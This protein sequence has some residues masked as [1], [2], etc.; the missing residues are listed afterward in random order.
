MKNISVVGLGKLGLCVAAC[1]AEKDYK[2]I[3]V[4]IDTHKIEQIN[5]GHNPIPETGLT[6]LVA[7]GKHNLTATDD[8]RQAVMNSEATFIV[9]ATPSDADGSFSNK[10]LE[11]SLREIGKVLKD[12]D[13]YHLIVITS[14][15]MPGTTEHVAK[16]I[17]ESTTGKKCG[18]D[19]G[20]AYNP[21]FIALGSVIHDFLNPDFI[22]IGEVATKDGEILEDIYKKTCDNNPKFARMS[23]VNA[24]IA[25]ISLN[26]YVTMK[27]SYANSLASI[28]E[29]VPGANSDDITNAIGLD[30][31]I[32][33]KYLKGGLGFGGPCFPRDNIA[34]AAFARKLG[35][36]AKLAEMV[37]EVNR[38]QALKIVKIVK[39]NLNK[40]G[41]KVSVLGLSYKPNAP[42][43]EDSQA[44]YIVGL[45]A[46]QGYQVSVWDPMALSNAQMVLGNRVNYASNMEECL[47]QASLCII[48]TPWE[49]FR[50][51]DASF[52]DGLM[53]KPMIVLDCWRKIEKNN[54]NGIKYIAVGK[55]NQ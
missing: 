32:G 36:K 30:T 28:C 40:K 44:V 24:E 3:G 1:F 31:R 50:S 47:Q 12:K 41:A 21:E 7:K 23:P 38:D 8:Y 48:A 46:E 2:V 18:K 14:T 15:V 19:F 39:E 26:C 6:E 35:A 25:K 9:V 13:G 42:V 55:G 34:F 49:Q 33:R 22:L 54:L 16:F 43:I 4:D 10:Q 17:L 52:L 51:I 29:R 11:E 20:L 45:L 53:Q 5:N 27:I 37:D